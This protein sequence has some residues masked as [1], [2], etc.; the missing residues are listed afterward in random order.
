MVESPQ[1][2]LSDT[3]HDVV[4]R[5]FASEMRGETDE[6]A[7]VAAGDRTCARVSDGLSRWFGPY[8]ARALVTRAIAR[9]KVDHPVLNGVTF[10][11]E[12]ARCL[13]GLAESARLHG[14]SATAEGLVAML[15]SLADGLGR[16][17]GN[18]I[19][20]NLLEQCVTGSTPTGA[21]PAADL[22]LSDD[23]PEPIKEP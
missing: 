14:A 10:T 12:S 8:G 23:V 13:T 7:S 9:A 6:A 18:D 16:L 5:L 20:E 15:A 21:A 11:G 22:G 17:I 1:S 3:W 2:L 4:R 19:A